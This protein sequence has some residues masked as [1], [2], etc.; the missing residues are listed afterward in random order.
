MIDSHAHLDMKDFERDLPQV[1]DRARQGGVTHIITIGIDYAS[2]V[3][4]LELAAGHELLFAS[5]GCHPHNAGRADSDELEAEL[6]AIGN[7]A[8]RPK[9]VAWGEIG[10]D[11]YRQYAPHDR[12]REIFE[13]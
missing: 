10:L 8:S 3:K 6:E 7:L 13:R 1:L 12:Q 2:S 5:V 11:F 4:G 9:V